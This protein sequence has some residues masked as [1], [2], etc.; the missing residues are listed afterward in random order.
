MPMQRPNLL[1]KVLK[2]VQSAADYA[3][4]VKATRGT[5]VSGVFSEPLA[6]MAQAG[7][8]GLGD[9]V[10]TDGAQRLAVTSAW[11][12]SDLTLLGRRIASKS[13]RPQVKRRVGEKLVDLGNHP[14]ERLLARPNSL[15]TGDF[16]LQYTSWWYG[17]RGNAYWFTSTDAPGRG[18][19]QEL[20]PLPS[21]SVVPQPD[22]LRRSVLTGGMC[23][24]YQ[25]WVGGK[26]Y[27]LPGENMVHFRTPNPFDWWQ[28]ISP[29]TAL[30]LGVQMDTAQHRW[31]RDFFAKENAVPTAIISLPSEITEED[32]V[33]AK[34]QIQ[35]EFGR[36]KKSAVVRAGDMSI[37]MIQQ[38]LE[39]MQ[40][41]QS[42][43]FNRNEIDRGYGVPEGLISGGLSGDSRLAAE[44]AFARNTVQPLLD[45]FAEEMTAN[46]G[47]YYGPDLVFEAPNVVP[48]ERALDIQEMRIYGEMRTI[49]ENR[50][51]LRLEPISDPKA[52]IPLALLRLEARASASGAA[53]ISQDMSETG[54]PTMGGQQAPAQIVAAEST[55]SA[56]ED[57]ALQV[58][59][60]RWRKVALR[61]AKAGRDPAGREFA[62]AVVPDD[63]RGVIETAL[64][65]AGE[66]SVK[67]AFAPYLDA[68]S[69][70]FIPNGADEAPL[71]PGDETISEADLEQA[72]KLWDDLMPDYAGLLRS[73][74]IHKRGA[75]D[76]H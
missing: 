38:T 3:T 8:Y 6:G 57:M 58:E 19:P 37:E 7:Q 4:P 33:A 51:K 20:W 76:A 50:A 56:A 13:A 63:V 9:M 27:L 1:G 65:G 74:V 39:Q 29:L 45:A 15:M 55:R 60:E 2:Y 34:L 41:V 75:E 30:A 43:T 21:P 10:D 49:N 69:V 59:L 12:F 66:E 68:K 47:P 28:G 36:Q 64:I 72:T 67:A 70:R 18:E 71:S 32:F 53:E 16:L 48:Q 24:D 14:F 31:Q 54:S 62:S 44:I 26:M 22:T 35:E 17:L 73:P 46:I 61:E 42:R 40:I 11:V 25:Y 52:D 5:G 23:I